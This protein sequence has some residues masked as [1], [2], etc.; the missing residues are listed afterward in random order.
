MGEWKNKVVLKPGWIIDAFESCE[1]KFYKLVITVT[2]DD[3]NQNNYTVHVGRW[4]QQTS[5]EQ[6]KCEEKPKNV[7]IVPGKSIRKKGTK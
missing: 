2:C 3:E 4:N 6:S 7:L 5:V 1:P